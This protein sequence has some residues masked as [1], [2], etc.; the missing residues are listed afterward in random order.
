LHTTLIK[1]FLNNN[2]IALTTTKNSKQTI[3]ERKNKRKFEQIKKGQENE[4]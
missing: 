3:I 2:Q 1:R 4:E